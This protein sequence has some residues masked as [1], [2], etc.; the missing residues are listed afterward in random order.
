MEKK[1]DSIEGLMMKEVRKLRPPSFLQ[2][3]LMLKA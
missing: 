1:V 2:A 3:A